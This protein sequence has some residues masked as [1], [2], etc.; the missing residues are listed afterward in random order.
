MII[1]TT[2]PGRFL[3]Q[4]S[5]KTLCS[6]VHQV[7][8]YCCGQHEGADVPLGQPR[9]AQGPPD[10]SPA[11]S[12]QCGRATAN[13]SQVFHRHLV[14]YLFRCFANI[15]VSG[16]TKRDFCELLNE[17]LSD[18]FNKG[19]FTYYLIMDPGGIVHHERRHRRHPPKNEGGGLKL[20]KNTK[21][22]PKI[23]ILVF[24]T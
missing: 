5:T 7:V 13:P 4:E 1:T 24:F 14:Q 19:P 12:R 22:G 23:V 17:N 9:R 20:V 16:N 15:R 6:S 2:I 21:N 11:P 18:L 10:A 8:L 3:N